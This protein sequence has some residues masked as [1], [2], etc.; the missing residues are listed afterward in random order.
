MIARHDVIIRTPLA[1]CTFTLIT[2][3]SAQRGTAGFLQHSVVLELLQLN[4]YYLEHF[5]PF[6][7]FWLS[8]VS[9]LKRDKVAFGA[10]SRMPPWGSFRGGE[11]GE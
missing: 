11:T 4:S 10:W 8:L 3:I 7:F 2:E 6:L 1:D 5:S 9:S